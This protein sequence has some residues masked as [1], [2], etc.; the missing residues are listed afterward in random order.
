MWE[1]ILRIIKWYF[2]LMFSLVFMVSCFEG[3][4]NR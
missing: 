4:F 3:F 1:K 2:I